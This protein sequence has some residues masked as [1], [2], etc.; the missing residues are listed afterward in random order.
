MRIRVTGLIAAAL[1]W[2]SAG[3]PVSASGSGWSIVPSANRTEP[4]GMFFGV[5]CT[6]STVCVAVGEYG[7]GVHTMIPKGVP[8]VESWNGRNW[9]FQPIPTR[10]GAQPAGLSSVSCPTSRVCTAV[11]YDGS[12]PLV[13]RWNGSRW[14][15]QTV[16]IP[17]AANGGS[18]DAVTCIAAASCTAVGAY[19]TP[20]FITYTLA[21]H[22]NGRTWSIVATPNPPI[23]R[24]AGLDGISCPTANVCSAV[25]GYDY[26]D[27]SGNTISHSFAERWDGTR[28][29]LESTPEPAGTQV[30][31]LTAVSCGS[32]RSCTAVG[33]INTDGPM[34]LE[35][36]NGKSWRMQA[37]PNQNEFNSAQLF[38]VSCASAI[39]CTFVASYVNVSLA[40]TTRGM[41]AGRWNGTTWTLETIPMPAGASDGT[42]LGIWCVSA[43][44]CTTVGDYTNSAGAD[45]ALAEARSG[46]RWV[47]Q[48]TP[49]RT[50]TQQSLLASVSCTSIK[51]CTA[52]GYSV[53]SDDTTLPL[54]E[55]WN[56]TRWSSQT[57]VKPGG[58][59]WESFLA[60]VSCLSNA[61]CSAVGYYTNTSSEVDSPLAEWWN[62]VDWRIQP[63]ADPVRNKQEAELTA[64]S[65]TSAKAC[66][67]VGHYYT[68]DSGPRLTLAERWNGKRW[69]KLITPNPKGYGGAE[70]LGVSCAGPKV[71]TA[72]GDYDNQAGN[73]KTLVE[74]W[75]GKHWKVQATPNPAGNL[76]TSLEGISCLSSKACT[77]VGSYPSRTLV[78]GWNGKH[79]ILETAPSPPGGGDVDLSGV[80]CASPTNCTAAGEYLD[81]QNNN[82]VLAERWNAGKWLVQSTPN[83][84]TAKIS[85][86]G[87]VSCST[88]HA[89]MAAG[90]YS[91][92]GPGTSLTLTERYQ[93]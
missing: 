20:E 84:S 86:F 22:W 45:V 48:S 69:A 53:A 6:S 47:L 60:G 8:I 44:K 32:G 73:E 70:F 41:L 46:G 36:W 37:A 1:V 21:E 40:G 74:Q 57:A 2:V 29:R 42:P 12:L 62:G 66:I 55:G 25:G 50:V 77:A 14:T 88:P 89:C 13:E 35:H 72:V 11:G 52:V 17:P 49:N 61:A 80:S 28:W 63:I 58:R 5:S 9:R 23:S 59:V 33:N 16:S 92:T 56:G 7:T 54:A 68:S 10:A 24:A 19:T 65:C 91:P 31:G 38:G 75:N 4:Q 83:P 26:S 93:Q 87:G 71:C 79:W 34:L 27:A 78:E 3:V 18:F 30:A 64:V 85:S 43:V 39:A 82:H 81:S 67:A 51:A 15:E 76:D 90:S